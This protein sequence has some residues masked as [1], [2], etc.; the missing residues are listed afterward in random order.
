MSYLNSID[1]RITSILDEK[2]GYISRLFLDKYKKQNKDAMF[3]L[4]KKVVDGKSNIDRINIRYYNNV[5]DNTREII[6]FLNW[7]NIIPELNIEVKELL[8]II[9][10]LNFKNARA[11][12]IGCD[13]RR[14]WE[15]SRIKFWLEVD[16][17]S[18]FMYRVLSKY[19]Y[20]EEMLSVLFSFS[21]C[22]GIN[23]HMDGSSTVK[24]HLY[25]YNTKG[26]KMLQLKLSPYF[27]DYIN[28]AFLKADFIF[29]GFRNDNKNKFVYFAHLDDINVILDTLRITNIGEKTLLLEGMKPYGFGCFSEEISNGSNLISEYNMYYNVSSY[30][31]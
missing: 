29:L 28:E 20:T 7:L 3:E 6:K 23:F 1:N 31:K 22:F 27:H 2:T 24:N 16:N 17:D 19:G 9:E 10:D 5:L 14:D 30:M 11:V 15:N 26:N 21:M 8:M 4:S 13:L 12:S 25:S 18:E